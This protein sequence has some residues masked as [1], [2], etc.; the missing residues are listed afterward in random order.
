MN[1]ISKAFE[2][3]KKQNRSALLSYTV[4]CD[5]DF[6]TS[7]EIMHKIANNG[8]TALE[9]GIPHNCA[10][11]EGERIQNAIDRVLKNNT[12]IEDVFN[13]VKEFRKS[14]K[15]TPVIF[16]LY[17][18]SALQYGEDKFIEISNEIGV[19]G[20]I[21]VDFPFPQNLD[22]ASKCRAKDIVFIQLISPT[23]DD[24]RIKNVMSKADMVYYISMLSTTGGELK[25]DPKDI[26]KKYH[27]IKAE[28]SNTN[29]IIGFGITTETIQ[30]FNKSDSVVVG[31]LLCKTIEES[32]RNNENI[33]DNVG[34]IIKELNSK[35]LS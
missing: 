15:E 35:I 27:A 32:I 7:L 29:I 12:R 25:V 23:T 14:N 6:E 19:N 9:I 17:Y 10:V 18:N 33:P 24:D 1:I 22:F 26:M 11:G 21:I 3:R 13:L 5:P 28:N 34:K 30:E 20:F 4:A 31:S 16:M 2:E 8:A